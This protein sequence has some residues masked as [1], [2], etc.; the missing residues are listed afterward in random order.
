M[1]DLEDKINATA[2]NSIPVVEAEMMM[3]IQSKTLI[4]FEL[5]IVII[6]AN[7]VDVILGFE[8]KPFGRW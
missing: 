7:I 6:A 1:T 3:L 5:V 2:I 8:A 4:F